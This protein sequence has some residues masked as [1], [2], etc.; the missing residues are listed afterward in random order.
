MRQI[1]PIGGLFWC[2]RSHGRGRSDF[3]K[4]RPIL[5]IAAR[6]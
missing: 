6:L 2:T 4:L 3:Y 5:Y 1:Y